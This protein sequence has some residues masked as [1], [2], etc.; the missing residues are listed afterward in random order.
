MSLVS[1]GADFRGP[2]AAQTELGLAEPADEA[3]PNQ[4]PQAGRI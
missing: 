3:Q 4:D 1:E 2:L